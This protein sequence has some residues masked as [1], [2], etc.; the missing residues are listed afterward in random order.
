M[1]KLHP[2]ITGREAA[3]SS[4]DPIEALPPFVSKR[5]AGETLMA[6]L[7]RGLIIEAAIFSNGILAAL[8]AATTSRCSGDGVN[9]TIGMIKE[10][11]RYCVSCKPGRASSADNAIFRTRIFGGGRSRQ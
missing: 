8:R 2:N 10:F 4:T 3:E 9:F 5:R 6:R 7:V 1:P 11:P